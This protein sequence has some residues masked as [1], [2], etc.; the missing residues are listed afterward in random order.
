MG[1]PKGSKNR[2]KNQNDSERTEPHNKDNDTN[3]VTEHSRK[4]NNAVKF[5]NEEFT[6]KD[7]TVAVPLMEDTAS[8]TIPGEPEGS[9]P[10]SSQPPLAAL[11]EDDLYWVSNLVVNAPTYLWT[12]LPVRDEKTVIS[13]NQALLRYCQKKH[14]D[15]NDYLFDEMELLILSIGLFTTYKSEY[16]DLY[17]A[18]K[19]Q[20]EQ[21]KQADKDRRFYHEKKLTEEKE[22]VFN[23]VV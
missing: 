11:S 1:R 21:Q 23:N 12:K 4:D 5:V 3:T 14:I 2:S 19:K 18:E 20:K 13:F 8:E 22:E 6:I 10:D 9:P 17:S 15:V 16:K 7:T